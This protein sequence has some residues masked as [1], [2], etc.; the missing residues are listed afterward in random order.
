[1][2][3]VLSNVG[4]LKNKQ[5]IPNKIKTIFIFL[6]EILCTRENII[7]AYN[8]KNQAC[9]KKACLKI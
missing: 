3:I 7:M 5:K 2:K 6:T 8:R 4:Y 9:S 1:M